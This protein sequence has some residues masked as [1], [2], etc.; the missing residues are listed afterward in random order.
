MKLRI[1][2][3]VLAL[4]SL[5]APACAQESSPAKTTPLSGLITTGNTFQVLSAAA[6]RRSLTIQNNNA[7]DSCQLLVGGPWQAGDTTATT[8]SVNGASI[9]AAK[10]ALVL[11][12]GTQYGRYFP[13]VPNDQILI[14]CATTGDSY[15]ADV[16]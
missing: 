11:S 9:A 5:T 10:A 2:A 7:T 12:A 14:T 3:L 6:T 15:Y 4:L 16:Q 8:R 13:F 1:T